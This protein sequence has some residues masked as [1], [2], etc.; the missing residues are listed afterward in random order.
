M[1]ISIYSHKN[2]SQS[3]AA[4]KIDD[5]VGEVLHSSGFAYE[6][7][8]APHQR[9]NPKLAHYT[10]YLRAMVDVFNGWADY[11][12][13]EHLNLFNDTRLEMG[14]EDLGSHFTCPAP[15]GNYGFLSQEEAVNVLIERMRE[16]STSSQYLR[17][18]R[19]RAY[20]SRKQSQELEEYVENVMERYARTLVVRVNFYYRNVSKPWIKVEDVFADR[21]RLASLIGRDPAFEHLSGYILRIEQADRQ[22]FHVHGAFFFDASK[23]QSEAYRAQRIGEVWQRVTSGKGYWQDSGR[24]WVAKH[25]R[26]ER[27]TTGVF[28]RADACAC[29]RVARYMTYLAKSSQYLR[30]KPE[31]G[32]T[33]ST[34]R[35][36][37]GRGS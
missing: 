37:S 13:S 11:D 14:L 1:N 27:C 9:V 4:I 8:A 31:N 15:G 22:G 18:K 21:N 26:G 30:I 34:G 35:W 12:F 33:Y 7:K 20:E 36:P 24:A 6:D 29:R 19:D 2:L 5:F 3:E 10:R 28:R 32:R 17:G 23:V 16:N 25:G